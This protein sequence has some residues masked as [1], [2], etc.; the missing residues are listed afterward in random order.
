MV[1]FSV[2][3]E[4]LLAVAD[5]GHVINQGICIKPG[6]LN[7]AASALRMVVR[8]GTRFRVIT[9]DDR[10]LA[11]GFHAPETGSMLRWTSGNA[12]LPI[13]MFAGFTE[14]VEAVIH[15]GGTARHVEYG[16]TQRVA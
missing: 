9:M 7:G 14:P 11:K 12:V 5:P 8:Q 15:V 3:H 1:R 13:E 10:R 4:Y 6:S 16:H 2:L